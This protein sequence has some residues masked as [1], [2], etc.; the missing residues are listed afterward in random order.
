MKKQKK[1]E[2][3]LKLNKETIATLHKKKVNA[4]AGERTIY[5]SDPCPCYETIPTEATCKTACSPLTACGQTECGLPC[6]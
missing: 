6:P 3:K 1:F 4:G 2:R 5:C